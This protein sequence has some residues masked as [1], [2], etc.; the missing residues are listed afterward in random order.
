MHLI[1]DR[2]IKLYQQCNM[3]ICVCELF[4]HVCVSPKFCTLAN[5]AQVSI[6]YVLD[7][8]LNLQGVE[9]FSPRNLL[10]GILEPFLSS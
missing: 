4:V 3:I 9:L 10:Q 8:K 5:F 7:Y 1:E 2:I 6:C